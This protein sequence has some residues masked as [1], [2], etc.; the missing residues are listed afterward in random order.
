[1]NFTEKLSAQIRKS[2]FYCRPLALLS[3]VFLVALLLFK[4][5]LL[6]FWLFMGGVIIYSAYLLISG[7]RL[8]GLK[9]P[10]PY[11]LI[12]STLLVYLV[13][14]PQTLRAERLKG[15]YD[16]TVTVEAVIEK[17]Y[18]S[19][20][21]GSMHRVKLKR[22]NG[23]GVSGRATLEL[24]D[25][26]ELREY[27]TVTVEASA[28][29]ALDGVSGT[30]RLGRI[31]GDIC[32]EL[33]A[34]TL[35]TVTGDNRHGFL[36]LTYRVN[37]AMGDFLRDCL[38]PEAANYA[39]ALFVGDTGALPSSFKRDMSALG[40]S[41]ILAVSGMHTSMIASMVGFLLNRTRSG[42]RTKAVAVSLAGLAFM[43]IAGLSACVVRTVI[44]LILS[45]T[46][47]FF[48]R[49]GDSITALLLSAVVIC[50]ISPGSVL[51]CSLLL[52]F[53]ATLGIV[54]SASYISKKARGELYKSRSGEMKGLY[55][56]ARPLILAAV[57][58][59]SAS[60]F[61]VPII[62]MY[63]GSVSVIS[64]A[65]NFIAV[66]CSDYSM[67]LLAAVFLTG[68]IPIIGRVSTFLF[69]ALYGFLVSFSEFTAKNFQTSVSVRYPFFTVLIIL[70]VSVMFFLRL[71]GI[72]NP[73]SPL[74]A[75][76][77]CTVIFA[78]SV[79]V[80]SVSAS[81]RGEVIYT[82]DK[83]SEGLLVTSGEKSL[84]IDIGNG[85]KRVPEYAIGF[86]ETR[87]YQTRLDAYMITH[88]HSSHIGTLRHLLSVGYI[89]RVYLPVPETEKE[90]S[91]CKS[92]LQT[93][94]DECETVI[95]VR[96]ETVA[97]YDA[98][99]ETL[100]YTLLS[101][102]THPPLA[103]K[104]SFGGGSLVW[105][106]SSVMESE[107][108]F[109]VSAMLSGCKTAIL[110][111]HGPKTK[112]NIEFTAP[113]D[114]SVYISPFEDSSEGDVFIGGSFTYLTVDAEGFSAAVFSFKAGT[115]RA[116]LTDRFSGSIHIRK[117]Q[118]TGASF[119]GEHTA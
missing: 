18:Y 14:L 32:L 72:R 22:I 107:T 47:C 4:L 20:S 92:I 95:F 105:L 116:S 13:S 68:K 38:S 36:Y 46:P 111:R 28:S 49:R 48:G 40:I 85:G 55:R 70:F 35:K 19:E 118:L 69:E 103:V 51:S 52:S 64:V 11:L 27:D 83:S 117:Q 61:T 39:I 67:I 56:L 21:F 73:A 87:Y 81:D 93:V 58:S 41:H 71:R 9:N 25:V 100:P 102:S 91:F 44:M 37:C 99:I 10:L 45:V 8:F 78:F 94:S 17:T 106:G 43:C 62:A 24:T 110:G 2:P 7:K 98:E 33:T 104:V 5:K 97:F 50:V 108:A 89:K 112:K 101:R 79:Q 42:R 75:F 82:A 16:Q 1:M 6:W 84:Y 59:I 88:Y 114:I 23:E 76:L 119:A 77:V 15:Y 109:C 74:A 26:V 30:E 57:V 86:T 60:A 53:F 34:E 31:S 3:A 66:P 90:L 96:G 65:A 80:Y 115:A 12:F 54:L 29:N 113:S 63:F